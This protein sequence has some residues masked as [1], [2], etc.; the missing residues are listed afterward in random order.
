MFQHFYPFPSF[1][2]KKVGLWEQQDLCMRVRGCVYVWVCVSL[3]E[4]ERLI[5]IQLVCEWVK[6]WFSVRYTSRPRKESSTKD[7]TEECVLHQSANTWQHSIMAAR[8][9]V[10]RNIYCLRYPLIQFWTNRLGFMEHGINVMPF[11]ATPTSQLLTAFNFFQ[12]H[13][14]KRE[15]P[16]KCN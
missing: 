6:T 3:C 13:R 14:M 5:R 7:I 4:R 9:W 16:T 15:K 1:I 10:A 11:E 8:T 12:K 2:R